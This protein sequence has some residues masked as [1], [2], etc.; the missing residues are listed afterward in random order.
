MIWMNIKL[1]WRNLFRNK[2]RS[3]IAGTAMGLG[4]ASLIFVDALIIGMRD[5]MI[6]SATSS[7]LGEGQ[8][9]AQEYPTS[10]AVEDTIN[11][12]IGYG[13]ATFIAGKNC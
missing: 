3:I 2:R 8:I 6:R 5:N 9:H 1:A 11:Q 4:L 12:S 7:F 13:R 10:R